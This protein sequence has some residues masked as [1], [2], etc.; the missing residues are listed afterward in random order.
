[1]EEPP[2]LMLQARELLATPNHERLESLVIHLSTCQETTEYQTALPLFIF[3]THNFANCLTLKLLQM[4][5]SS[6]SNGVLRSKSIIL[7]LK[8][9]AAYK[10]RRFDLSLVA[11]YVIKPL[12]ISC[13][14]MTQEAETKLFRRIVSVIAHD[15]MMLDNGGWDELSGFIVE[16]SS[17]EEPLKALH[18]FVDLPPVPFGV[19]TGLELHWMGDGSAG[20]KEAENN[21]IWWFSRRTVLMTVPDSGA[22]RVTVPRNYNHYGICPNYPYFLSQ[23]PVALIYHIFCFSLS[24]YAILDRRKPLETLEFEDLLIVK[25]EGS[26]S[27]VIEKII[28]NPILILLNCMIVED[29]SLGLQAV[30]KLGIQVLDSEMR[31]DMVKGLLALLVKAASDLVDKGME[32]FLVRGLADLEMFLSQDKKLCN[33]N[34]DQCVFVSVFL[35]KIKDLGT[36]TKE[37]TGKI[38]RLVKSTPSQ[39]RQGHGACSEREWFDRLNSLPP[40]EMLRIFAS[41]NVEERFRELAIR[42]LNVLLSDHISREEATG[43]SVLRELQP[44]LISCLWEKEGVSERMFK[45]LGEVVYH[46]SYEVMNCHFETWNGLRDYIA[47][48]CKTEFERAVYIF[49]CL[50]IWLEHDF[51]VPILEQLLPEI[52]KRLN[53]PREVLVDNSCWVLAFLGAFCAVNHLIEMECYAGLVMEMEDKMV[54]SVRELVERE[55]EVGFVRRAF[56]DVESIVKKQMEWFGKNEYK[57]I[58]PLLQR[59]YLIKGMTMESKMVLWRT[60]VFVDRGMADL[61]EQQPDGEIDD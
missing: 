22:T 28:L 44:L 32:V 2:N 31:L 15:V 58:K 52:D 55:M 35:F 53:P 38:H 51:V 60:N 21:A 20:T 59:L 56:R 16:L 6:S 39:P 47:S 8:T 34:K 19:I 41:T 10:Y 37:A 23:P 13:L 17:T 48:N 40:L 7:L 11:L 45:V 36:L 27:L 24:F 50:T 29:W 54:N 9:L 25:G 43:I 42:R 14:R 3:C 4:Y 30:V 57:L 26:I 12:V 61:D 1:M 46:V 49:Q 5:R 33:Y 18:V